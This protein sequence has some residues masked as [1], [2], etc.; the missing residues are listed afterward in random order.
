[1]RYRDFTIEHPLAAPAYGFLGI[2]QQY[3][4]PED[5]RCFHGRTVEE[6]KT[7]IDEWWEQDDPIEVEE[8]DDDFNNDLTEE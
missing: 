2:Q 4:G 7:E 8:F 3:D 1:M 6:V 5:D